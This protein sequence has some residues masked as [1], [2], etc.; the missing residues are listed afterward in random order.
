[1]SGFSGEIPSGLD[2]LRGSQRGRRW[3][4]SLPQLVE[5]C[6]AHWRLRLSAPFPYA[7]TS[8][9]LPAR[10]E[11]GS[12]VVL[13][14]LFVDRENEHE[15]LALRHWGGDGAIQLLDEFPAREALLLERC[16]PG[17][18]LSSAGPE[19]AIEVMT[20]LLPRLWKPATAPPFRP[21]ADEAARWSTHLRAR[22]NAAGRPFRSGLVDA[23]L[24]ALRSLPSSQGEQ[25]LLHQD[26]HDANVLAAE[27]EPW[28]A[29]DPKPLVGEREF[30]LAPIVRSAGFESSRKQVR[31]R[32]D[33]LTDELGL[34]RE[35]ARLWCLAQT[36][37]WSIGSNSPE[38]QVA[39][40][41]WLSE[42]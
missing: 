22:W 5:D 34:D 42:V 27:R 1:M 17:T 29:I 30:G 8:L 3:L 9:A 16:I 20:A 21:L 13:K 31:L 15:A 7:F 39:I 18:P 33:R 2:W 14:L 25:V 32:L 28:L 23:A 11:D 10:R 19:K 35:R 36:V 37:A 38:S 6:A 41:E 12:D 40:A 24:D 4:K 26:L